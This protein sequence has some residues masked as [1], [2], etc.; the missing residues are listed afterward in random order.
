MCDRLGER[1]DLAP[2]IRAGERGDDVNALATG[3]Q[4][5]TRKLCGGEKCSNFRGCSAHLCEGNILCRIEIEHHAVGILQAV[6][7]RSPDMKLECAD[8]GCADKA[9]F[10]F[11]MEI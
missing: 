7:C 9:R 3:K 5:K 4:G 11:D 1:L 8:L 6:D 10:I 2:V